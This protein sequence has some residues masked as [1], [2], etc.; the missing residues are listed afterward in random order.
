MTRCPN[1]NQIPSPKSQGHAHPL[2]IGI[3][4]LIG[5][6]VLL[7]GISPLARA[8]DSPNFQ[9][10]L[11]PRAWSFPRDHGRHD[12]FKIEWW[13]FTGN[14]QTAAG[15]RFGYQLTF[16]RSGFAPGEP[17]RP[18]D[19]GMNDLYFAHAAVSDIGGKTFHF[20]D[21]LQRARPGLAWASADSLDVSLLNWSAKQ[22]ATG[23]IHLRA[24]GKDFSL[25]LVTTGGRGPFLEGP[26]GVN[27]K[28]REP[29]QASFY[30]SMTRLRTTGTVVVGGQSFAVS[31]LSWMD[32]EFSSNSLGHQ[33]AGWDWMGLQLKD[34]T[35]LMIYRL[36]NRAGA[37]DY[38]SG[39][40][41][42]NDGVPH[43]LTDRDLS[44]AGGEPWHSDRSGA[45]YPQTW[46]INVAGMP[47]LTVQ[48]EMPGQELATSD[49]T[50]VTYFEGA[51][52]VLNTRGEEVGQGYLEMTGYDKPITGRN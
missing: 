14:L 17:N 45:N 39:T 6:W 13:Y 9:Q 20:D 36:R 37:T 30:Y 1:R 8:D 10:A 7:I 2:G 38:L 5:I 27:R 31:G 24:A 33:Q 26:G 23:S 35:D 49:S 44:L 19:W 22:D 11:A 40:R 50:D 43:Y 21:A 46:K 28:G 32:H 18:S 51:A 16:F 34:G 25:D 52:K 41:V 12:N 48:S 29:G 42:G 47:P 3:W 4:S 15:R